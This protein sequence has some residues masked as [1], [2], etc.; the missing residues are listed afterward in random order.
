MTDRRTTMSMTSSDISSQFSA[1]TK[2]LLNKFNAEADEYL[3]SELSH[4]L[5]SSRNKSSELEF[6]L[7][8]YQR[9]I[10]EKINVMQYINEQTALF[11]SLKSC[12]T[13]I[14]TFLER[15]KSAHEFEL[16]QNEIFEQ[17]LYELTKTVR[18]FVL[19]LLFNNTKTTF[20]FRIH[21]A[22]MNA[23]GL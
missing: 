9:C 5:L 17:I 2:D 22:K 21:R 11:D 15:L 10:D 1:K 16:K 8:E 19:V 6:Y 14:D 4:R 7:A 3:H 13:A 12:E 23:F 18:E 20:L